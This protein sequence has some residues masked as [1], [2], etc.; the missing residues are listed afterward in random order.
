MSTYHI[1]QLVI[2]KILICL[3]NFMSWYCYTNLQVLIKFQQNWLNQEVGQFVLISI[4]LII[5]SGIRR[6]C[7][8]SERSHSLYLCVWRVIKQ[9]LVINEAY[10]FCKLH[11]KFY[12]PSAVKVNSICRGNCWGSSVWIL[13]QQVDYWSYILHSSN[14]WERMGIKWS[15]VSAIYLMI[16]LEGRF[17]WNSVYKHVWHVSF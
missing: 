6:I 2:F 14:P 1:N 4:K 8:R 17:L 7:V 5:L 12:P 15:T 11:T 9:T 3:Y 16:H 13:T 10:L